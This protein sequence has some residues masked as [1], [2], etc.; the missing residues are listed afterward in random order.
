MYETKDIFISEAEFKNRY[1]YGPSDLLGEGGFAQVYKAFD[2]QFQEFVALK[3]YNKGEKGKYDVLHEMKDSRSFSHKNIIRVHD[4]FVVKFEHLGTINY[5]QVGVIELA[6]G[7]NLRD[8]INTKPS[9]TQFVEVLKG[10]LEGLEYLHSEKN[11]IHRDLSPENILMFIEEKRIIPKIADF[12]ISKK[13]NYSSTS[14]DQKKSTQLVGKYDYMAPEQFYPDKFGVNEKINTQVDLWAFG[15]ILFELFMKYTPFAAGA[16]ENPMI[17]IQSICNDPIPDISGIPEPYRTIIQKCLEKKAGDRI[18]NAIELI[19][20]LSLRD[21]LK[22]AK[23]IQAIHILNDAFSK[24]F[25]NLKWMWILVSAGILIVSL[26]IYLMV[27][28]N[29]RSKADF[30]FVTV[31]NL[32]LGKRYFEALKK[33]DEMPYRLKLFSKYEELSFKCNLEKYKDDITSLLGKK[34]YSK[35]LTLFETIPDAYR[36]DSGIVA[37]YYQAE[38]LIAADSL[39]ILIQNNNLEGA[40]NYYAELDKKIKTR[41]ELSALYRELLK[42]TSIDSLMR[43]GGKFL[44]EGNTDLAKASFTKV[45]EIDPGNGE[46]LKRIRS[47]PGPL[48]NECISTYTGSTL[49]IRQLPR[50]TSHIRLVNICIRESDMKIRLQIQPRATRVTIYRK[51]SDKAFYIVYAYNNIY[52]TLLLKNVKGIQTDI[53]VP[54]NKPVFVDLFFEKLPQKVKVFNLLQGNTRPEDPESWN[55][56]GIELLSEIN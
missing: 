33:L 23:T 34:Q 16:E 13:I 36:S 52:K 56:I 38:I 49:K 20:L 47:I 21:K 35:I 18:R 6:N 26:V 1:E 27:K 32:L 46:A 28:A 3:F 7:G 41:K 15:I 31:E 2:R 53:G 37:F 19:A 11:I 29:F 8:F 14:K 22:Q 24:P 42:L 50:D 54:I 12:G 5:V 4:A 39:N 10:I 40:R 48:P 30:Q 9:E 43:I 45:L 55:F 17:E 25:K 44:K 51:D